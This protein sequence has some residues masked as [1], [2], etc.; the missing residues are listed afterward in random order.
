MEPLLTKTYLSMMTRPGRGTHT[1]LAGQALRASWA[2]CEAG[3]LMMVTTMLTMRL[4]MMMVKPSQGRYKDCVVSTLE[5]ENLIN[6]AMQET[7]SA[8]ARKGISRSPCSQG[9]PW[10]C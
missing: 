2:S 9:L 10:A 1:A 5:R 4:T 8:E 3:L 7:Y 6:Q